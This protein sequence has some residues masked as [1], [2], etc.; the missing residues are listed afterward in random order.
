[1]LDQKNGFSKY[2]LSRIGEQNYY[3]GGLPIQSKKKIWKLEVVCIKQPTVLVYI[4]RS[5]V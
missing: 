1:V 3:T 5:P 4:C 2:L